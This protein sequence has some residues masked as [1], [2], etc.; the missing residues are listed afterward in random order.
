MNV[1]KLNGYCVV[2]YLGLIGAF[3]KNQGTD[4]GCIK[5]RDTN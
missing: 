2:G 4:K 3:D 5:F 1:C